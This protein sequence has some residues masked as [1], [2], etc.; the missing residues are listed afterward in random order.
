MRGSAQVEVQDSP[1]PFPSP[2]EGSAHLVIR[3]GEGW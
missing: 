3:A 2:D 1:S